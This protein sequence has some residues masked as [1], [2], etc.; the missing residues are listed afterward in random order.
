MA[1]ARG[2]SLLSEKEGKAVST[3]NRK[4][5]FGKPAASLLIGVTEVIRQSGPGL[6]KGGF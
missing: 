3:G 1:G 4:F 6:W 5:P 2:R